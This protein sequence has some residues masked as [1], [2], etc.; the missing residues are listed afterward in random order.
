MA[1][2]PGQK[3][4]KPADVSRYRQGFLDAMDGRVGTVKKLR[5]AFAGLVN[6][7]GGEQQVSDPQ[8]ML[9]KRLVHVDRICERR[10]DVLAQGGDIDE[11]AYL[12]SVEKCH[13]LC[14]TLGLKRRS[15]IVGTLAEILSQQEASE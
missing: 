1:G 11:S 3:S 10:E 2:K 15:K 5:Q 4:K 6:H 14:K 12:N 9:I 13:T 8:K 7:L